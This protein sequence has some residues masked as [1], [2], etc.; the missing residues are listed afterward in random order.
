MNTLG[1]Q[2]LIRLKRSGLT[3][4]DLAKK[5]NLSLPTLR[6]ILNDDRRVYLDDVDRV[7]KALGATRI[8]H[9]L[10]G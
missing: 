1:E 8:K 4:E 6:K 9:T 2:L 5:V 3:R 10:E 7:A